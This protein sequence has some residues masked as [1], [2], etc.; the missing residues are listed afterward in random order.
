M[1]QPPAGASRP[2]CVRYGGALSVPLAMAAT[3]AL[4][5]AAALAVA[6]LTALLTRYHLKPSAHNEIYA[7]ALVC[8]FLALW[9]L[10]AP[11]F[12]YVTIGQVK[13]MEVIRGFYTPALI[14][15][16]FDQFWSGR[17]GIADLVFRWRHRQPALQDALAQDLD[18]KFHDVI[19]ED[20]GGGLYII[21]ALLLV[22]IGFLVLFFGFAG[23]IAYAEALWN[24][25]LPPV[26]PLG[27]RLDLVSIAAIFGAYTW[28]ASD[29]ITRGH[30]WTFHPSDLVWYALRLT[31]RGTARSG[32]RTD[33]A[34]GGRRGCVP[35]FCHQHV[36]TRWDQEVPRRRGDPSGQHPEHHA[37]GTR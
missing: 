1:P 29:S 23:G 18:R 14:A 24:K 12:A 9:L 21:P 3:A 11:V 37:R 19:I 31:D 8:D 30:L 26:M 35:G 15:E 7:F 10:M 16:Y 5:I 17:D 32:D 2:F 22:T 27:L 34:R 6:A 20:F 28:I 36:F 4:C 25:T 13:K 33:S